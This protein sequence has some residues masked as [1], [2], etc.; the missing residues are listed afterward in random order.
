MSWGIL[1]LLA[2][3]LGLLVASGRGGLGGAL[4]F[5]RLAEVWAVFWGVLGM[6]LGRLVASWN[7]GR[8]FQSRWWC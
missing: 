8:L 2:G 6:P 7:G 5:V 1:G 4:A 3:V